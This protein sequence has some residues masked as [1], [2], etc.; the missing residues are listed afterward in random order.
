MSKTCKRCGRPLA[1]LG[2]LAFAELC[3]LTDSFGCDIARQAYERGL[4]AGVKLA[5]E[6]CAMR[7]LADDDYE[8]DWS[9]VDAELARRVGGE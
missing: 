2:G 9:D 3:A 7:Y 6:W 5:R 1:K 8:L 4:R